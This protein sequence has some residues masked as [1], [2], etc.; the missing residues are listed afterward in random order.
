MLIQ[1]ILGEFGVDLEP[2]EFE[3]LF[4]NICEFFC[5]KEIEIDTLT[6][7]LDSLGFLID[8]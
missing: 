3:L 8:A 6:P 1:Q 7:K 4:K 5:L 2:E